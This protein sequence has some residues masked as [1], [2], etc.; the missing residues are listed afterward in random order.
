MFGI[1]PQL[2]DNA[3]ALPLALALACAVPLVAAVALLAAV[4]GLDE[5]D[6][7]AVAAASSAALPRPNVSR[8]IPRLMT[9]SPYSG[10]AWKSPGS[11]SLKLSFATSSLIGF[12]VPHWSWTVG[13]RMS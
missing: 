9:G 5:L 10:G 12:A 8:A 13:S 4:V 3:E 11:S 1:V 7:H 6:E 2:P